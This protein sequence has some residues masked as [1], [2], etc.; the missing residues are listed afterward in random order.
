MEFSQDKLHQNNKTHGKLSLFILG[1]RL[2]YYSGAKK[3][4]VIFNRHY[5]KNDS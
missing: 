5:K 4:K 1:F 2:R 3:Q